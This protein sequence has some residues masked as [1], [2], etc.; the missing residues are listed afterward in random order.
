METKLDEG[1]L[2]SL[3]RRVLS[4]GQDIY[5]DH[6]GLGYELMQIRMDGAARERIADF[7]ALLAPPQGARDAEGGS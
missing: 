1:K 4:Q 3:I 2:W 5:I 6:R 7:A